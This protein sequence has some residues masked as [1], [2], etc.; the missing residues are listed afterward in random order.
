MVAFVVEGVFETVGPFAIPVVIF[1]LGAIGYLVLYL[2]YRWRDDDL[3]ESP[4]ER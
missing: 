2:Y 1:T 4:S 3:V